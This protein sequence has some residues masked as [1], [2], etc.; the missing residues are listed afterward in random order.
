MKRQF[1]L[2]VALLVTAACTND[3]I[4]TQELINPACRAILNC[5]DCKNAEGG[6][7]T[8][9]ECDKKHYLTAQN[10]CAY[11]IA[12]NCL[13]CS[14]SNNTYCQKCMPGFKLDSHNFCTACTAGDT[15]CATN[16]CAADKSWVP[17]LSACMPTH[18]YCGT[19]GN[20]NTGT[21][22]SNGMPGA[23]CFKPFNT[24]NT[25]NGGL[26]SYGIPGHLCKSDSDCIKG[27]SCEP[28]KN[29]QAI[30][31]LPLNEG[32]GICSGATF[33]EEFRAC[34][35]MSN[36]AI[37][38]VCDSDATCMLVYKNSAATKEG[39]AGWCSKG[40]N[41]EFCFTTNFTCAD[42]LSCG[43]TQGDYVPGTGACLGA[44]DATP[45]FKALTCDELTGKSANI[46]RELQA[47]G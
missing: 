39:Y 37:L 44:D 47:P 32:V 19:L 8:C 42:N 7:V 9:S 17:Q 24:E 3:E 27:S 2:L 28:Y 13:Q 33:L 16:P 11:C 31:E 20:T 4:T 5:V 34:G 43:G 10:N 38:N 45:R 23:T 40:N 1:I 46:C 6:G 26:C 35:F 25:K 21:C 12:E 36:G 29:L 30:K 18:E 15:D 14:P 41:L 22:K